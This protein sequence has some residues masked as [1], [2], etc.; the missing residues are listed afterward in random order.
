[1]PGNSP[2]TANSR[3]QILHKSNGR[4]YPRLRPHRKHL[5]T[6]RVVNFGFFFDL[7][8]VDVFAIVLSN[9]PNKNE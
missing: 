2:R 7:A 3:K 4:I 1:M 5:R 6:T 8:F 9:N